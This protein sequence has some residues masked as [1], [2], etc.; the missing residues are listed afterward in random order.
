MRAQRVWK[1]VGVDRFNA[2][3][4]CSRRRKLAF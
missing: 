3:S 1:P 2:K 4:D